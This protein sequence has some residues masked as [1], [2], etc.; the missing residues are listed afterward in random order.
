MQDIKNVSLG[1]TNYPQ[2]D[3]VRVIFC[4]FWGP[5]ISLEYLKLE[6]PNFE[7]K[8]TIA[9]ISVDMTKLPQVGLV[10]VM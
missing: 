8:K 10:R 4:K 2:I 1:M 5:I 7:Y 3:V 6:F 9:S